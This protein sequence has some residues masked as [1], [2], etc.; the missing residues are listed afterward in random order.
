MEADKGRNV[1]T[2]IPGLELGEGT[3]ER[4]IN[5]VRDS[6]SPVP[7]FQPHLVRLNTGRAVLVVEVPESPNPPHLLLSSGQIYVRRPGTS[8]PIPAHDRAAVD[9][10]YARAR[11]TSVRIESWLQARLE[12]FSA[13]R[14][15]GT[16]L[17]LQSILP[18]ASGASLLPDIFTRSGAARYRE[19]LQQAQMRG[20]GGDYWMDQSGMLSG[21]IRD[22]NSG[23]GGEG[24]L[25]RLDLNGGLSLAAFERPAEQV[26]GV[27]PHTEQPRPNLHW[28]RI[29]AG[30]PSLAAAASRIFEHSHFY[31]NIKLVLDVAAI[32][33]LHLHHEDHMR[34][35]RLSQPLQR[36][37]VRIRR[38]LRAAE[39]SQPQSVLASINREFQRAF[40]LV[41]YDPE[42][43]P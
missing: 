31:G 15:P 41:V 24:D 17:V 20:V 29:L 25:A 42:P 2:A 37:R 39:L 30:V 22:A 1:V 28:Q 21:Y 10:L 38:L 4:V 35:P 12:Q 26:P 33:G 34:W 14:S 36:D 7:L 18:I 19:F 6:V 9:Q 8:D 3:E 16:V 5:I 23:F 11:Q 43:K 13:M 27:K 32:H 40:G